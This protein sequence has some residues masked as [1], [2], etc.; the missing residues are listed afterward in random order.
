MPSVLLLLLSSPRDQ[1]PG[2][3]ELQT[4]HH[5]G[6][7][8]GSG[9]RKDVRLSVEPVRKHVVFLVSVYVAVLVDPVVE[10]VVVTVIDA[11]RRDGLAGHVRAIGTD[12]IF[13]RHTLLTGLVRI[14]VRQF[15]TR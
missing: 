14:H 3:D 4:D 1:G 7:D 13:R 6:N 11:A 5:V 10:D 12:L 9:E 2:C 15:R 8:T